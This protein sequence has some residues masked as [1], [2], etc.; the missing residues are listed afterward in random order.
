MTRKAG[1]TGASISTWPDLRAFAT[2]KL[3]TW[4]L[5]RGRADAA[6]ALTFDQSELD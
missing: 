6:D 4:T 2:H 1:E 5:L 3:M